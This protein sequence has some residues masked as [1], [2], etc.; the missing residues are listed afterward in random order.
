MSRPLAIVAI[1]Q[2]YTPDPA[3]VGRYLA[4]ATSELVRRGHRVT[5]YT[6][7]R[8]YDD[9]SLRYPAREVID[10]VE[11]RRLPFSWF[12]KTSIL[13]RLI[14][15]LSFI[16]QA[17]FR[18]LFMR[19][20]D[21]LLISTTPPVVPL[22]ALVLRALRRP[23][24][25][26][27]IMDLNPD[28]LVALGGARPGS[29]SVRLFNWLNR[30]T[31]AAAASII[32]L[33]RFMLERVNRKVDVSDKAV[34]IPPWMHDD[35]LVAIPREANS[36]RTEHVPN[37]RL[38]IM[39]SGNH[40][41]ANPLDTILE[42]AAALR[43]DPR[44]T[45]L[46]VGGGSRKRDVERLQLPNVVSLP[47]QPEE[48]L[49]ESLSAGDVHVI[50]MGDEVVGIVHPSK[51]YA[52]LAIGRPSLYIGPRESPLADLIREFRVGWVLEHGDVDGV[53][54]ALDEAAANPGSLELIGERARGMARARLSQ[55]L[56][57][58]ALCDVI[59]GS[60]VQ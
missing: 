41:P 17:S 10:G 19:R 30:K 29:I 43:D 34:V 37:E 6:A 4:D 27:W 50:T 24:L 1:S 5:V 15:G 28:Q 54:R 38:A 18:A 51:I 40:S 59:D 42:A 44:F 20:L 32:V 46:F 56:L 52:A 31:L 55:A 9:P 48:R 22:A 21:V 58:S 53:V 26:Y 23:R 3:S 39:Y 13:L 57:C 7:A 45:F 36:F 2:V 25:V 35:K 11:V 49:P 16:A 14:G 8:G 33:D 60:G 47:Y 12:G